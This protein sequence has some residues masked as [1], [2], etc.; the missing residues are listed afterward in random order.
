MSKYQKMFTFLF[1]YHY[2]K[3]C[4]FSLVLYK[5]FCEISIL[6]CNTDGLFWILLVYFYVDGFSGNLGRKYG[7]F[8]FFRNLLEERIPDFVLFLLMLSNIRSMLVII[9][10]GF[11]LSGSRSGFLCICICDVKLGKIA[12]GKER[13]RR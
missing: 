13:Q 6:Y 4:S 1:L 3:I 7:L 8:C 5:T 9:F 12:F 2:T 10:S 11:R